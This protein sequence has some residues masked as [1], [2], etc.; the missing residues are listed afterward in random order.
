[1]VGT[2]KI[3]M[4]TSSVLMSNPALGFR[5][6]LKFGLQVNVRA[7]S[8]ATGRSL[9]L[10]L[11]LVQSNASHCVVAPLLMI[12]NSVLIIGLQRVFLHA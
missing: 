4:E 6:L 2:V 10:L 8:R 5:L 11:P 9:G 1:M 12:N 7:M 3:A